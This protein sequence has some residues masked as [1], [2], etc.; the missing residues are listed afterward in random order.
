[1]SQKVTGDKVCSMFTS[2]AKKYDLANH[3]LSFGIDYYWRYR[4]VCL[5][6][7][8]GL[9]KIIDMATGSGDVAFALKKSLGEGVGIVGIDFCQAM[10][11]QANHKKQL[12]NAYKDIEFMCADGLS[13][14]IKDSEVDAITIAFGIRNYENR[15][16]GLREMY[17]VLNKQKGRLYILEFSRPDTWMRP[18]YKLYI[19]KILPMVA[20]CATGNE[21]AYKYLGVSIN[22]F[23][24][25]SEFEK[26]ILSVGFSRVI[27]HRMTASIVCI[28]ECHI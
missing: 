12:S 13:L 28:H 5:V 25:A 7:K 10:L 4:L 16:Q 11:D 26:E 18:F 6:K 2:I 24:E 27:I 14:P 8:S 19:E 17:R 15:I 3:I 23:P 9:R 1:M 20:R 21:D 22:G